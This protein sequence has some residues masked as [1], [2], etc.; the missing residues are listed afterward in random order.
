MEDTSENELIAYLE[1][2]GKAE[3]E[4]AMRD[5]MA[6][7]MKSSTWNLVPKP[8]DVDV[9]ACKW[10]YKLKKAVDGTIAR[11]KARLVAHDFSQQYGLDYE[12]V[13]SLVAKMVMVRFINSLAANQYWTM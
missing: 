5:E 13:F 11:R 12:E 6:A 8:N 10:V 9:I 2:K 3:W 1:A 4:E 7:L